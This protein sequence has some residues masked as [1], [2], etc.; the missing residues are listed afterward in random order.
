MWAFLSFCW[1]TFGWTLL[2][3]F[4]AYAIAVGLLL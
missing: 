4:V 2:V 1:R 3:V